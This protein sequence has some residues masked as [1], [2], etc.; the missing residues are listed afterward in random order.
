MHIIIWICMCIYIYTYISERP[1][2]DPGAGSGRPGKAA[3]CARMASRGRNNRPMH[4]TIRANSG[5]SIQSI[6]SIGNRISFIY[7]LNFFN[8]PL[9]NLP[10]TYGAC[11]MF[12]SCVYVL[13]L[14]IS[15]TAVLLYSYYV[16]RGSAYLLILSICLFRC[17]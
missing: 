9:S 12:N 14:E 15:C 1:R 13:L 4:K 17:Y 2:S 11:H 6:S 5:A 10:N 3:A 8:E 7:S 16:S